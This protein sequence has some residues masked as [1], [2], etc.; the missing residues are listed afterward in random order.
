M[1]Y[2]KLINLL[3]NTL[4]ISKFRTK[5]WVEIN[6]KSRGTYNEDSQVRFKTSMFRSNLCDYSDAYILV[7]GGVAVENKAAQDQTIIRPT[8][9]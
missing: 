1:E 7:K 6:Y 3:E 5:N 9:T 8:K 4:K 2:Q